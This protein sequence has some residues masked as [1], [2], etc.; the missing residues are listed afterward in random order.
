M[1]KLLP[2]FLF[3]SVF[4]TG[5]AQDSE[6]STISY[7]NYFVPEKKYLVLPVKNGAPKRNVELWVD[8]VNTRSFDIELAEDKPN[9][10][11][12][13]QIDQWKGKEVELRVDKITKGSR[14]FAR[15]C[16]AMPTAMRIPIMK[17]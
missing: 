7:S 16:K 8:G 1:K 17:N 9:W 5:I 15:L 6:A 4:K 2:I 10:Y 14:V 12:Y 11:A 3:L 13:L